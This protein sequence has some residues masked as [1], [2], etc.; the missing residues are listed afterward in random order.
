MPFIDFRFLTSGLSLWSILYAYD[1]LII[2]VTSFSE[3]VTADFVPVII[4]RRAATMDQPIENQPTFNSCNSSWP[5]IT[6]A[7]NDQHSSSSYK[8]TS[9]LLHIMESNNDFCCFKSVTY[10]ALTLCYKLRSFLHWYIMFWLYLE[11]SQF[12]SS[13]WLR[14][15]LRQIRG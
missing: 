6:F 5:H 8:G 14:V 3:T 10:V 2:L 12:L 4:P 9:G 11:N 13:R 1:I 7:T 15:W